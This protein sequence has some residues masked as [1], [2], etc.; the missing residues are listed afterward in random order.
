MQQTL[1][2]LRLA[3]RGWRRSKGLDPDIPDGSGAMD[4]NR[5]TELIEEDKTNGNR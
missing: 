4:Q 3:M 1:P 2:E 5:L